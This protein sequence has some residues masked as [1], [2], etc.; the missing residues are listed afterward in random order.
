LRRENAQLKLAHEILKKR[1]AHLGDAQMI[2]IS[3]KQH[4]DIWPVRL[5]CR[6]PGVS[7]SGFYA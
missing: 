4:R 6:V 3:I 5:Q 1:S 2:F 7:A